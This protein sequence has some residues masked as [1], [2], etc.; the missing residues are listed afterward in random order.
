MAMNEELGREVPPESEGR[1]ES[2][3][4]RRC[5]KQVEAGRAAEPLPP[6]PDPPPA[7]V[8]TGSAGPAPPNGFQPDPS[9]HG[10]VSALVASYDVLGGI[11]HIEGPNLPS[12]D[13]IIA[14]THDLEKLLFPGYFGEPLNGANVH[15]VVGALCASVYERLAR[16]IEK[17]LRHEC[18]TGRRCER[19]EGQCSVES[20]DISLRFLHAIPGIR[21]ILKADAQATFAG[22]PAAKSLPEILVSYPGLH[23]VAVQRLAHFLYEAQVPLVPRMMCE[24][25]HGKTGIDIH[26]GA[27]IGPGLCID[28]GTG[29]VIGETTDIGRNVKIYQGVTLGALSVVKRD[30]PAGA[31]DKRHP[32]LEDNVTI[33][34]GATIL[35]GNTVVGEGSI[36]GGN[37]WLTRSVPPGTKV[38]IDAPFQTFR[39]RRRPGDVPLDLAPDWEI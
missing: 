38:L 12:K 11:N 26:P 37:V 16:E 28:H 23:A 5:R 13:A 32:T 29:V 7:V 35:G 4:Q 6:A 22:D 19:T 27:N 2:P 21:A 3:A 14:L 34:A 33:Y 24:Y 30:L 15:Y 25:L 17:S 18:R 1:A 9:L 31:R 20:R 39:S 10:A 36:I 8:A